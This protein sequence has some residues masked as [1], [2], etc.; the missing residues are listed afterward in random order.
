MSAIQII[1]GSV[2]GT[3]HKTAMAVSKILQHQGYNTRL[4]T[5]ARVSDLK[6]N[7]DV[8]LICTSTTGN[9]ELPAE[10]YPLYFALDNGALDLKN[11]RYG[12]IG[13]GDSG[14]QHF[15]QGAYMMDDALYRAGAKRL[16]DILAMDARRVPNQ[17]LMAAQWASQWSELIDPVTC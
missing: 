2:K 8:I 4:N 12:V 13:L 10:L 14:Y 11:R 17:A 6:D 5:E 7:D 3:A 16:G 9:G 15:A 1:V